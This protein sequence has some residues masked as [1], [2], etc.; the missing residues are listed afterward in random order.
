[1]Y[2]RGLQKHELKAILDFIYLGE[3]KV[4]AESIPQFLKHASELQIKDLSADVLF[5]KPNSES[6]AV[7]QSK[8]GSNWW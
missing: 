8:Q 6:E 2:L 4:E 1:M 7:K 5:H 3:A